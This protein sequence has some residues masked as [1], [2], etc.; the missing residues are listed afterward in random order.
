[1]PHRKRRTQSGSSQSSCESL[2]NISQ[3]VSKKSKKTKNTQKKQASSHAIDN[4]IDSVANNSQLTSQLSDDDIDADIADNDECTQLKEQVCGLNKIVLK[5]AKEIDIL[6]TQLKFVMSYIG[7]NDTSD[8][9]VCDSNSSLAT[10]QTAPTSIMPSQVDAESENADNNNSMPSVNNILPK[11]TKNAT[12][13][14]NNYLNVVKNTANLCQSVMT[15]MHIEQKQIDRR[16]NS[17]VVSGLPIENDVNDMTKIKHVCKQHVGVDVDNDISSV[18]RLGRPLPD[19]IQPILVYLKDKEKAQEIIRNARRLRYS[20]SNYIRQSVFINSNMTRAEATAA[21]LLR[22]QKRQSANS[23]AV[24]TNAHA[25]DTNP[26]TTS[27]VTPIG[28]DNNNT[29][30]QQ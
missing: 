7:I 14:R 24:N 13:G 30:S 6:K 3:H 8:L 26:N 9:P 22:C 12:A 4:A 19:K 29:D 23:Q 18:K 16:S 15:A 20:L 27:G 21:Y 25:G 1:M 11:P 28:S 5:Q 2:S 10:T 17:F